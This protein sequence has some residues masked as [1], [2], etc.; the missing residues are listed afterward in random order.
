MAKKAVNNTILVP[1]DL[2]P[3]SES[4]LIYA[5]ELATC[6]KASLTV[7]YVVHNP[8]EM[9][10]YYV[11]IVKKKQLHRMQD[12]A[13]EMLGDFMK[14]VVARNSKCA[15]LKSA[16]TLLVT[17]LPAN[18]IVEVAEKLQPRMVVMGSQG[19]TGLARVIL[20]SKAEHVLQMSPV[21]VTIVKGNSAK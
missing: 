2:S 7:L 4:A 14:D 10:D 15:K 16:K 1:V 8:E 19:R 5:S 12:I 9:P 13:E 17:G 20:G 3:N 18:R 11:K 6:M 21:P